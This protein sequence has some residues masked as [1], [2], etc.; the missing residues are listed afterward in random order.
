M[1]PGNW[2]TDMA[3]GSK[4]GYSLLWVILASNLAAQFLQ[5][6]C[7]RLGI[8]TGKDLA[9]CCK[10]YYSRPT[11]VF[12]WLLC[13][14]AIIACDLAE[15]IGSAVAL[16]LLFNIP[17]ADGVLITAADVLLLLALLHRGYRQLEAFIISLV[18]IIFGCFAYEMFLIKPSLT[19]ILQEGFIP[20]LSNPEILLIAIGIIGATVM[21]H[22]LYLH[23]ALVKSRTAD[24]NPDHIA[25][26]IRYNTLDT[27]GALSFAF[28]INA[29]ILILA[30][31][32]FG[33]HGDVVEE[34]ERGHELLTLGLGTGAATLFAV[35]LLAAGQSST[36]TGTLAGQ[37][38][39]EGF[40]QIKIRPWLRRLISRMLAIIPAYILI[41]HTGGTHTIDLLVVSQVVLSLQLPF[42]IFPLI[43][44][45]GNKN[46]MGSYVNVRWVTFIGYGLGIV[47]TGLN[48]I[49]M[50]E[51]IWAN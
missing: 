20:H 30:A 47:M 9:Q 45:T 27:I 50:A 4:F 17:L 11:A 49:L 37:V 34:L 38:V 44:F 23:S 40:L 43:A 1:D 7:T 26:A 32:V 35:A 31:A 39:M 12:L 42:A 25:A 5:V 2:G 46:I 16:K 28:L 48:L 6:L 29:A 13:E 51:L 15:V 33:A 21:P 18:M 8:V 3:A 36:I 10:E 19:T 24:R 14:I 22:N 41:R